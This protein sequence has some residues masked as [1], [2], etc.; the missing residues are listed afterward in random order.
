MYSYYNLK[1][2][3]PRAGPLRALARC[4]R[5][6]ASRTGH[7]LLSACTAKTEIGVNTLEGL[8]EELFFAIIDKLSPEDKICVSLCN[9]RLAR[10]PQKRIHRNH[11]IPDLETRGI[12]GTRLERDLPEYFFCDFCRLLHKYD[13]Y[14]AFGMNGMCPEENNRL[15]CVQRS[16]WTEGPG[17]VRTHSQDVYSARKTSLLQLKLAVR[18]SDYGAKAEVNTDSLRYTQVRH[19][20][21]SDTINPTMTSL[22]SIEA[23]IH[24][25]VHGRGAYIRM[26][27][28]VIA[29]T[30]RLLIYPPYSQRWSNAL[31]PPNALELCQHFGF[32]ESII[33]V[34]N[35]FIGG[36]GSKVSTSHF[37][38]KCKTDSQIDVCML[39]SKAALIMTRWVYLGSG[40]IPEYF[41]AK[42]SGMPRRL[43]SYCNP[44]TYEIE[45]RKTGNHL[46]DARSC[47]EKSA[48]ESFQDLQSRNIS[49]LQDQRYEFLIAI[50]LYGINRLKSQG[51]E[52]PFDPVDTS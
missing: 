27:D 33:P 23:H 18:R 29:S 6:Y 8:P 21:P 19:Y 37:C 52:E 3:Q 24:P 41:F 32:K 20:P 35:S 12:I 17:V 26:Q 34:V 51:S 44:D 7:L 38:D 43:V 40:V 49:Y 28:I 11:R 50:C 10:L 39:G 4:T 36:N 30:P 1:V 45:K 5:Y 2:P 42:Y 22:F 47:F 13:G 15:P 9:H 31:Y 46:P 48:S 14:E 16:C 25:G